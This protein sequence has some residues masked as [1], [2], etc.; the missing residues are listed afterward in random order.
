MMVSI[1]DQKITTRLTFAVLLTD[2][3]TGRQN[4]VGKV[5]VSI[6]EYDRDAVK[7]PSSYYTF[8]DLPEV[9]SGDYPIRVTSLYYVEKETIVTPAGLVPEAPVA[10]I[11]LTPSHLYPFPSG[12][13]LL[14]GMVSDTGASAVS[15]A[16]VRWE[17]SAV[18]KSTTA[19][20][21]GEFVLYFPVDYF[22]VGVETAAIQIQVAPPGG[23]F[24]VINTDVHKCKTTSLSVV[25]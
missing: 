24:T 10:L 14:R 4:V 19:S 13:T 8:L 2:D 7:N 22:S 11:P 5:R 16:E 15:G 21:K 6:S 25:I 3:Y 18:T 23:V 9:V 1:F 20:E 12:A 17:V